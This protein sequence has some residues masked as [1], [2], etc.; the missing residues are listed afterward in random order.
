MAEAG[1]GSGSLSARKSDNN[2][3]K[4]PVDDGPSISRRNI[5]KVLERGQGN[6]FNE[7]EGDELREASRRFRLEGMKMRKR[8]QGGILSAVL[9]SALPAW[10]NI[11]V[12]VSLIFGGCCANVSIYIHLLRIT[13]FLYSHR[14]S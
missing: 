1:K 12:I 2:V 9:L 14:M 6:F 13:S 5:E 3:T 8:E 7:L 11:V 4:S 10:V